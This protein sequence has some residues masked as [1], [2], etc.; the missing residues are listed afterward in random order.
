MT[1][2]PARPRGRV[3]MLVDNGVDGDSRV[4][5]SARSVAAAGWDVTLV[6]RSPTNVA[7]EF[8]VGEAL[9]RRVSVP[10]VLYANYRRM[11]RRG[12]RFLAAYRSADVLAA[13]QRR[14]ELWGRDLADRNARRGE[15]EPMS[16][17]V[18]VL[19]ARRYK[20]ARALHRLRARLF[21]EAVRR[22]K[23]DTLPGTRLRTAVWGRLLGD[24]AWRRLD[25]LLVD[26]EAAYAPVIDELAPDVIH[27]HDFRMV[28]IAVR[29]ARRLR[30]GGRQVKVV[31]DAH[32]FLPGVGSQ[33]ARWRRANEGYEAGHIHAADAV[34]TV[35]E[36]L[37]D[38]LVTH[39]GLR[40][41][42][43][44]VLN[45][46]PA[47]DPTR[48]SPGDVRSTVGLAADT[49]LVVYTG[50]AARQR[51]LHTMVS[52]LAQLPGVHLVLVSK[53]SAYVETL[54]SLAAG[55]GVADRLHV[56]P[57]VAQDDVVAYISTASAGVHPLVH[58]VDGLPLVNHEVAL[59]TKFFDY[60][61]AGLPVVVSDVRTMAETVRATGIGEV[62]VAED[63]DD[64]ARAVRAVLADPEP[65]RRAYA[66]PGA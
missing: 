46:P 49:P 26:Y 18:G 5:K 32:E 16:P 8:R 65:Y 50:G 13:R 17:V 21:R 7:D 38:M 27:A 57:Y 61:H 1:A 56:V 6:G 20:A 15:G 41:R 66:A 58:E 53:R 24:G 43:T 11:P 37:A 42:P 64:L 29:A 22:A 39:H 44:V 33:T 12:V 52:A 9:V 23:D 28:G 14:V 63:V 47:P 60:A 35:S 30:A 59:A 25:P 10:Y 31:Y 36:P 40:T 62:F 2:T 54:E 55:L 48:P 19:A 45:A 4:Q 34:V 51:G 3:V